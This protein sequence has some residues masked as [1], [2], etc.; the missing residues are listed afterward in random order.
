MQD[1][2]S[3]VE[4]IA[5]EQWRE[6]LADLAETSDASHDQFHFLMDVLLPNASGDD[7]RGLHPIFDCTEA[8]NGL[9]GSEIACPPANEKLLSIGHAY[10][11]R[12]GVVPPSNHF[13]GRRLVH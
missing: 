4:L 3:R 13:S 6:R 5:Y 11:Q 9:A 8:L 2:G 10:L 1:S 12:T 7:N